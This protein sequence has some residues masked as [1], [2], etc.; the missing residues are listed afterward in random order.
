[1][2]GDIGPSSTIVISHKQDIIKGISKVSQFEV[3]VLL[4]TCRC[5]NGQEVFARS[6]NAVKLRAEFGHQEGMVDTIF[7][8]VDVGLEAS[9]N[10]IFP[11]NINAIKLV[12]KHEFDTRLDENLT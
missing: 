2:A 9:L 12:V 4:R 11:I 1:M 3:P 6:T 8:A 5:G 10:R 7:R